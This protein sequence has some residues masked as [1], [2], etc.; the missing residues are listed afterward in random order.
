MKQIISIPSFLKTSSKEG[1]APGTLVHVGEQKMK[2]ASITGWSY[3]NHTCEEQVDLNPA[4]TKDIIK[5]NTINWINIDGVHDVKAIEQIGA[6]FGLHSLLLEDILN[7][8]QRPKIEE[9]EDC[10]FIVLKMLHVNENRQLSLEQ[11]SLILKDGVVLS[12][13]EQPEDVF[14][15]VRDRIR[16]GKGKIRSRGADYLVYRLIDTVIDH[17]FSTLEMIGDQIEHVE[18]ELIERPSDSVIQSIYSL[19]QQMLFL[20][21]AV[22]PLREIAGDLQKEESGL[23]QEGTAIYLRDLHDHAMQVIDAVDTYRD[24]LGNMLDNY[25]SLMSHRMNSV[26]KTLTI[27]GAIFIPLTFVAGVYGMNFEHMP[28]LAWKWGYFVVWGIM[29]MMTVGMVVW[30]KKKGW[31]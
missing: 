9:Y 2:T 18:Q 31:L 26:M 12:F 3:D 29:I 15:V 5:K 1:A 23:M 13:Q 11:V 25:L 24:I 6:I 4:L 21:K 28:E 7:T 17:Y 30:F 8:G 27:V 20:R 19:R 22:N 14:D 16:K 10:L